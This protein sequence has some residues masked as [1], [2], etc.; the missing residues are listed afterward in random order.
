MEDSVAQQ[1]SNRIHLLDTLILDR[2]HA[3]ED[4]LD[5]TLDLER[6]ARISDNNYTTQLTQYGVRLRQLIRSYGHI[7]L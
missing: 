4:L 5:Q 7:N 1:L 6:N 3:I 2:V